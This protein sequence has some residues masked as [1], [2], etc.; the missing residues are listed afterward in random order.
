MGIT[1]G[2]IKGD[3]RGLDRLDC[4]SHRSAFFR[5]PWWDSQEDGNGRVLGT[6]LADDPPPL[7]TCDKREGKEEDHEQKHARN[8]F[9][10]S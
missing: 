4:S 9:S 8:Q 2:V 10:L 7:R 5:I 3:T 6:G 1:A